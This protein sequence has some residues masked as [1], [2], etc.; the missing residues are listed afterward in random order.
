M[1]WIGLKK[2]LCFENLIALYE[3]CPVSSDMGI[4]VLGVPIPNTLVIWASPVTLTL[5]TKVIRQGDAH[6][7]RVLRMG[8]P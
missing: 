4:F 8:M 6:I 5:I 2:I 7:T 3:K 1:A